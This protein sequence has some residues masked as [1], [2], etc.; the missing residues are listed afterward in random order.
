M[1]I[2]VVQVAHL[3]DAAG[4]LAGTGGRHPLLDAGE[5]EDALL[6][7]ESLSV[8]VD[9]LVGAGLNAE[10]VAM[11]GVLIDEDD[12][13]LGPL[14][15]GLARAGLQACRLRAVVTDALYVEVVAV[16]IFAGPW[17]SSQFGPQTGASP[18]GFR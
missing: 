17:S 15:D 13:V 8:E 14:V 16:G 12:A 6:G 5:A 2:L 4:A 11:A 9:A 7:D 18:L 3:A 10:A 1:P